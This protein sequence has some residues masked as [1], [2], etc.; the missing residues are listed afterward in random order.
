M[1]V[2]KLPHAML[3]FTPSYQKRDNHFFPLRMLTVNSIKG[4]LHL[5]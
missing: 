2:D 3:E 1:R 5:W 4:H